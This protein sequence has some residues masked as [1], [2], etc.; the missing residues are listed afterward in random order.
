[1]RNIKK[2][3]KFTDWLQQSLW[4]IKLRPWV[5]FGY[6]GLV[7]MVLV[8]GKISLALGVFAAVASLFVGVGVAKYIDM[9]ASSDTPVGF[10]WAV[11]K[12]LPLAVLAAGSI[13]VCWFVF[14]LV[15]SLLSG[16]YYKIPQF[17]FH[18]EFTPE[19][20]NRETTRDV[21]GWMYSYANVTLIFTLLMLTSFVGWFSHPLMLF[22]NTRWS[23]AKEQSDYAVSRNQGAMYKM[24]GFVFLEAV[25]CS[26]LTPLLTPVLYMLVSTLMYVSYKSI[27][28][29][30]A[31]VEV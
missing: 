13:V 17:F 9:K 7:G 29:A 5:W 21:V 31:D 14:M 19:N 24:L 26:T 6:S 11:N 2:K 1:M 28:E 25:L 12:S 16:E 4:F 22:K 10:A 23:E 30:E 20:L 15:A 27:F 3:L 18:W 8:L